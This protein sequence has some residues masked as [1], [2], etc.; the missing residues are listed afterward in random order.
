MSIWSW[1][2]TC[3][4]LMA[5][6]ADYLEGRWKSATSFGSEIRWLNLSP[7]IPVRWNGCGQVRLELNKDRPAGT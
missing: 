1:N 5:S 7:V 3:E 6:A 2:I 4:A